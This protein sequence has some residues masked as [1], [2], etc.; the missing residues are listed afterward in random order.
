MR[1]SLFRPLPLLVALAISVPASVLAS[2]G[3]AAEPQRG[4]VA[5]VVAFAS[6]ATLPI[7]SGGAFSVPVHSIRDMHFLNTLRQQ[8]DFSCGSAA[9][10]TLLTHHYS[11]PVSEQEVFREMYERGDQNKIRKEGFSLLDMKGY[12][13]HHGFDADGFQAGIEQLR[14]ANIPAIALIKENGYNHFVVIKGLRNGRVLVGDPAVGT[15]AVPN[16]KFESMWVNN[17]LF[18]VRNQL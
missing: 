16:D 5:G 15:R 1:S 11:Y 9:L 10:A 12:L 8:Y 7:Q 6:R 17:I 4:A 2:E 3:S 13:D 18:V 14:V